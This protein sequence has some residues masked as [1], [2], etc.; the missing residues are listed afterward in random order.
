MLLN[1]S[2]SCTQYLL[3]KDPKNILLINNTGKSQSLSVYGRFNC[4]LMITADCFFAESLHLGNFL[5]WQDSQEYVIDN[6]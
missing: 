2:T 3:L 4:T 6:Q 5:C 1:Y